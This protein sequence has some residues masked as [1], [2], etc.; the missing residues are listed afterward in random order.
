MLHETEAYKLLTKEVNRYREISTE[1]R[2]PDPDEE[3]YIIK[4]KGGTTWYEDE[5]TEWTG[6][7]INNNKDIV[8]AWLE[9]ITVFEADPPHKDDTRGEDYRLLEAFYRYV[10]QR[11][12]QAGPLPSFNLVNDFL[13]STDWGVFRGYIHQEK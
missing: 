7:Q 9:P 4:L 8:K 5:V 12:D 1:D 2:L 11:E 6:S 3:W 13:T 10:G